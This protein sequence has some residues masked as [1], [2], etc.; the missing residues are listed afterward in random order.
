MEK[1]SVNKRKSNKSVDELLNKLDKTQEKE[2]ALIK[3]VNQ[4][5][6]EDLND[7]FENSYKELNSVPKTRA[8]NK[9]SKKIEEPTVTKKSSESKKNVKKSLDSENDTIAKKKSSVSAK[10]KVKKIEDNNEKAVK[11]AKIDN[12]NQTTKMKSAEVSDVKK[13]TRKK[14][15]K[16]DEDKNTSKDKLEKSVAKNKNAKDLNDEQEKNKTKKSTPKSTSKS[17]QKNT[18]KSTSKS[19]SKVSKTATGVKKKLTEKIEKATSEKS[20]QIKIKQKSPKNETDNKKSEP[21]EQSKSTVTSRK[22][23]IQPKEE[24]VEEYDKDINIDFV[25]DELQR[26]FDINKFD[27]ELKN[28]KYIP[29][30][31]RIAIFKN[32]FYNMIL[33]GI[34][35]LFLVFCNYGY[36]NIDKRAMIKNLNLFSFVFLGISLMLI[37]SSYKEE[38]IN[39]CINGI[40][41]LIMGIFT[42]FLP[43]ILQIYTTQYIR[44]L[45]ISGSIVFVYYLVK[46][47]IVYISN[48]NK[49]IRAKDDISKDDGEKSELEEDDDDEFDD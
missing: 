1:S 20:G 37:E 22:R 27:K 39:K 33:A 29:R 44:S 43:Y 19:T 18:L 48:R 41:T 12:L 47:I 32:S 30:K 7:I 4:S 17:T 36:Y 21:K 9:V 26:K 25:E 6:D 34:C 11:S 46:S 13:T 31:D 49:Y 45:K 35:I 40:E 16:A 10:N 3:N 2:R 15:S 8:T 38:K 14:V 5:D 23:S 24:I 28:R 42:L